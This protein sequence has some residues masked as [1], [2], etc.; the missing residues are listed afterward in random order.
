MSRN[1]QDFASEQLLSI[2]SSH[3][4]PLLNGSTTNLFSHA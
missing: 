3:E 1:M 4:N 2:R